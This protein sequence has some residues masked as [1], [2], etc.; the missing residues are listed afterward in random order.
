MG[1]YE[2]AVAAVIIHF[3]RTY[4]ESRNLGIVGGE[5]G[6]LKILQ[7]R[8]RIPNVSFIRWDRLPDD[9]VPVPAVS[10]ELGGGGTLEEQHRTRDA[11]QTRRVLRRRHASG[12]D[13]RSPS[14][15]AVY[16]APDE[17]MAVDATG[18]LTGGDVLPGFEL[19]L[20]DLF[21]ELD[22]PQNV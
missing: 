14:A 19:K 8:I 6:M 4:L 18:S 3:L 16:Q 2:S 9:R 21:A 1:F 5:A 15:T 12:V 11:G 17:F 7:G 10:P 22:R 13:H 20:Q